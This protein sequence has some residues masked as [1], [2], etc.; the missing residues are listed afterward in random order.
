MTIVSFAAVFA[1]FGVGQ[2]TG[3][4]FAALVLIAG[5][6]TGSALWWFILSLG[7]GVFRARVNVTHLRFI[8][9]A[10]GAV[11]GGFGLAA[12]VSVWL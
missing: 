4:Y 7:V 5:I 2:A 10:A 9:K 11:I 8:N 6:F 1:S 12:V 3:G